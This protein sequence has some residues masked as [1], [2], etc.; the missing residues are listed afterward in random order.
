MK[1]IYIL[2]ILLFG[3]ALNGFSQNKSSHEVK[4]DKAF[5]IYAFDNAIVCY[6][7]AKDL[8]IDGQRKLAE[9]YHILGFNTESEAVYSTIVTSNEKKA[10]DYYKYA[11]VLKSQKKYEESNKWMDLFGKEKPTDLRSMSYFKNK[12]KLSEYLSIDPNYRVIS[13]S[14]NTA[15]QDFGTSYYNNNVVFASTNVPPKMVKR[16]YNWNGEPY[17]DVY[18]AEVKD[19]QLK[20]RKKMDK[21]FKGKMHDGPASFSNNGTFMAITRNTLHD[22]TSD[23]IVELQISFSR[24][25]NNKWSNPVSFQYNNES[26]STG[27]AFLTEDGNT[28]YFV[29]NM[30]G[31]FGGTDIYKTTKVGVDQWTK[32]ENLG[33]K[34]NTE[35]DELFPFFEAKQNVLIFTSNG[36]FGLGGQDVFQIKQQGASWEDAENLGMPINTEADDFSFIFNQT[37]DKGYF[38]SNRPGGQRASDIYG[39]Q[40]TAENVIEKEIAGTVLDESGKP[41]PAALVTLLSD[42]ETII[43]TVFSD[44]NGTFRFKVDAN[45]NY[46]LVGNKDAYMEG[47]AS[48]STFGDE[49]EIIADIVLPQVDNTEEEIDVKEEDIIVNHDLMNIAKLKSIYFD[50]DQ[51][52]IRPDAAKELDKIVKVMNKY[53]NMEVELSAHTDCRGTEAYNMQLSENRAKA[54][55]DYIRSR[56]SNPSRI[57]GKGKGES[58][59]LTTCLCDGITI[60]DCTSKQHQDNRRTE[61]IIR[62]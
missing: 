38:S 19:N 10:E 4:G 58:E 48:A 57:T 40:Y 47:T 30:P 32:P 54:T 2:S 12:E 20:N 13:Q 51:Y 50:F 36:H 43:T 29:S 61:F 39:F 25:E 60:S 22:K 46:D 9:S 56:I 41:I 1:N 14:I 49:K 16:K 31:G 24:F 21:Q 23:K 6:K 35:G 45:R 7:K 17:L 3:F 27:H 55:V 42:D 44:E 59:L 26:Y 34:V 15:S 37:M 53:P 18:V 62:K 11:M 8:T 28:M 33:N 52:S 5:F